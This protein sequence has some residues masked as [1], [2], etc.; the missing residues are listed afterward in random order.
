ML[1][2]Q[3]QI[4]YGTIEAFT[5]EISLYTYN[6]ATA[7]QHVHNLAHFKSCKCTSKYAFLCLSQADVNKSCLLSSL[8]EPRADEINYVAVWPRHKLALPKQIPD[9]MKE[10]NKM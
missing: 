5:A 6:I 10:L 7:Q 4:S 3:G 2:K 1:L 8:N 9:G